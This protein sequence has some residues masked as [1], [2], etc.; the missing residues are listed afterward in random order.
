MSDFFGEDPPD[1]I[2]IAAP[3]SV[4]LINESNRTLVAYD[5]TYDFHA[6]DG[7]LNSNEFSPTFLPALM[8]LARDRL[9]EDRAVVIL[10][11]H[12]RLISP[13]FGF[14]GLS[15]GQPLPPFADE[16]AERRQKELM[17]SAIKST[18]AWTSRA[19][20]TLDGAFFEDGLFIGPNA[21]AFFE[22]TKAMIDAQRDLLEWFVEAVRMRERKRESADSVFSELENMVEGMPR[23]TSQGSSADF[24]KNEKLELAREILR[25]RDRIGAAEVILRKTRVLET[26]WPVLHKFVGE[27]DQRDPL[28][29]GKP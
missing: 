12:T 19:T 20:I 21:S 18:L 9:S 24:Y 22:N 16:S 3:T 17:A 29:G 14:V 4:F 15:K 26:K 2:K 6:A 27:P 23:P 5:L 28:P 7:K 1:L 8:D 10:P 25:M 11:G 13:L